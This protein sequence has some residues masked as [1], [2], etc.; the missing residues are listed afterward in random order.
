[1]ARAKLS[2]CRAQRVLGVLQPFTAQGGGQAGQVR[3]EAGIL[4]RATNLRPVLVWLGG[5]KFR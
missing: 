2:L 1:M 5:S 4:S 3:G